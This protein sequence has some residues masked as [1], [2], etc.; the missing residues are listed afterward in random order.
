[1]LRASV[2]H[3]HWALSNFVLNRWHSFNFHY[4]ASTI[5]ILENILFVQA[6]TIII[7][8]LNSCYFLVKIDK[9]RKLILSLLEF[10][11]E[12]TQINKWAQ[13]WSWKCPNKLKH[14]VSRFCYNTDVLRGN[15]KHRGMKMDD[16]CMVCNRLHEDGGQLYFECKTVR[17]L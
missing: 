14:F 3:C 11:E 4:H 10:M 7:D 2:L 17:Q 15:Q 1:M 6:Q 13:I 8:M 9:L 5:T 12:S 16:T